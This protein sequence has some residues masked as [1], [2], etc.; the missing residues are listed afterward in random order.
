MKMQ[1]ASP[2][3]YVVEGHWSTQFDENRFGFPRLK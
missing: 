3:G 1:G 2:F